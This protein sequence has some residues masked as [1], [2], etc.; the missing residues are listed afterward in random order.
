MTIQTPIDYWQWLS[1][2]RARVM[3]FSATFNNISVI[4]W[5]SVLLVEEVE[6]SIYQENR[7]RQSWPRPFG[8]WIYNYLCNQSLSPLKLWVESRSLRCALDT[9]LVVIG[10]DCTGKSNYHTI[11]TTMAPNDMIHRKVPSEKRICSTIENVQICKKQRI[12]KIQNIH[13]PDRKN[14]KSIHSNKPKNWNPETEALLNSRC[15]I[16]FM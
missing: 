10:T 5:R 7:D 4:S 3:M 13:N 14:I 1:W 6:I 8:S 15:V 16:R 9:T 12:L 11:T 2:V